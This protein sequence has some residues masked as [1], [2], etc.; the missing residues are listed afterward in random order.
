MNLLEIK[1]NE[2]QNII[3]EYKSKFDLVNKE[4]SEAKNQIVNLQEEKENLKL[5]NENLK[6]KLNNQIIN[7]KNNLIM[8]NHIDNNKDDNENNE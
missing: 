1:L 8:N 6:G 7:S 3:N 2:S 5:E 4:L